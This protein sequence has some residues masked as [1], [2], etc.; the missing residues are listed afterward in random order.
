MA[1]AESRT[2]VT[3]KQMRPFARPQDQCRRSESV[4]S[5][6]ISAVAGELAAMVFSAGGRPG[7]R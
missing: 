3:L 1:G 4:S 2:E 6:V 5:C 7:D